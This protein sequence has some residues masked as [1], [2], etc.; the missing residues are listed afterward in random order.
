M[1]YRIIPVAAHWMSM[2]PGCMGI[3]ISVR[4]SAHHGHVVGRLALGVGRWQLAAIDF[5]GFF[6]RL[7]DR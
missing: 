3:R 5:G 7:T 2:V 1:G 4:A 6:P